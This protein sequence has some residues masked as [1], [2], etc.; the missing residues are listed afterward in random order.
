MSVQRT[1]LIAAAIVSAPVVIGIVYSAL[2]AAG[3][4]GPGADGAT[5]DHVSSVVSDIAT[6]RG[7]LWTLWV[8]FASTALSFVLAVAVAAMFRGDRRLDRL[9]RKLAVFALPFPHIV[10]ALGAVLLLSQS[11]LLARVAYAAGVYAS[12][13]E[14]PE[15]IYD[16]WGLGLIL[17]LT[18]KE[19][20]FLALVAFSILARR[21]T[22][23]EETARSLG[24]GAVR[25]FRVATLPVLWRGLMPSTI[26][27]FTFVAGNYEAT[28]LLAPSSPLA[29]PLLTMERQAR[30][31]LALRGEAYALVMVAVIMS[32]FAVIVH[33]WVA[34]RVENAGPS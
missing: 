23:L 30:S 33:E 17:A 34:S 22:E 31:A 27:V 11:G 19:F 1:G 7:L 10:A 25:T 3:I 4:V 2:G 16:R 5:L 18:W 20:S 32:L 15:L 26:A 29:L 13:G 28:V 12:P 6:W 24:A 14:M 9:G 21:G 8:A